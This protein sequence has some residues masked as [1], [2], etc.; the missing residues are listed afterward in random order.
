M[1]HFDRTQMNTDSADLLALSAFIS[2]L[3]AMVLVQQVS[4][5][6]TFRLLPFALV[7]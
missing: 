3:P 7:D 1:L 6:Y 5:H 2:V 4:G